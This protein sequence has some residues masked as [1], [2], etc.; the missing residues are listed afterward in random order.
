MGIPKIRRERE[1]RSPNIP[2]AS[3]ALSLA[4]SLL[5]LPDPG[6]SPQRL[7]PPVLALQPLHLSHSARVRGPR[8]ELRSGLC[9]LSPQGGE[10]RAS[11]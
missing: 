4:P 9:H 8:T 7:F 11:A 10:V 3:P 6:V 5:L 1:R 2:G